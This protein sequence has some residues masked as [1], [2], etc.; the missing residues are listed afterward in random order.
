MNDERTELSRMIESAREGSGGVKFDFNG[1]SAE[2]IMGAWDDIVSLAREKGGIR[3][4]VHSCE[5]NLVRCSVLTY[6]EF[7]S[8][9]MPRKKRMGPK[10]W[11]K[12]RVVYLTRTMAL[13]AAVSLKG[14]KEIDRIF[15]ESCESTLDACNPEDFWRRVEL[16]KDEADGRCFE[17]GR[18]RCACQSEF[19]N[20]KEERERLKAVNNVKLAEIAKAEK[21]KKQEEEAR[22]IKRKRNR[23]ELKKQEHRARLAARLERLQERI[24]ELDW[25]GPN[26]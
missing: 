2:T 23:Q 24:K 17:C 4:L 21:Q 14:N 25:G 19:L 11:H 6:R 13:D 20:S 8:E 22:W 26:A 3:S 5:N 16:L 10:M 9:Y 15:V 7:T 1:W 18:V 12:R